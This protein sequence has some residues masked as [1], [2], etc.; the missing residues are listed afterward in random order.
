MRPSELREARPS[1]SMYSMNAETM[2]VSL[3]CA[4]MSGAR[5]AS[6]WDDVAELH[7]V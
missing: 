2:G 7:V 4:A 1:L 5:R 3:L 6:G